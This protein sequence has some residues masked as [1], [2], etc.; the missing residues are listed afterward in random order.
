VRKILLIDGPLKGKIVEAHEAH[1]KYATPFP[2]QVVYEYKKFVICNRVLWLG[3]SGD[4]EA[5]YDDAAD[6]LLSDLAKQAIHATVDRSWV[7]AVLLT[8]KDGPNSG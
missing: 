7:P 4:P 2:S 6:L 8:E 3:V 1:S 5:S